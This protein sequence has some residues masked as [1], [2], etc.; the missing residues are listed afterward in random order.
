MR[1][2]H[3]YVF[4]YG[5]LKAGFALS[6]WME[7]ADLIGPDKLYGHVLTS[8]GPYPGMIF[9][10]NGKHSVTGEVYRMPASR[11]QELR[12]MEERAGYQTEKVTT[13]MQRPVYTFVYMAFEEGE[14]TWEQ[15][16]EKK[17]RKTTVSGIVKVIP[18]PDDIP[19]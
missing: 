3:V 8:L 16:Q 13:Y 19:F 11:F 18:D 2:K 5:S 14:Y 4:V 10:G 6:G 9:T 17:G 1:E 7:G 15:E 12:G